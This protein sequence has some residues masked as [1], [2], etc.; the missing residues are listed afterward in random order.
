MPRAAGNRLFDSRWWI[1]IRLPFQRDVAIC[2][3][4]AVAAVP[5]A[6]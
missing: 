1:W 4:G 2:V 6:I 3:A 5:C